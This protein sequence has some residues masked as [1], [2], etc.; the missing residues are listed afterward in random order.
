MSYF[1]YNLGLAVTFCL[2][3]PLLPFMLL[4][5]KRFSGGF[6]QRFGVYPKKLREYLGRDRPIWVHAASVGE[7]RAAKLLI[8]ALRKRFPERRLV[9][10]TFTQTGNELARERSS[11]EE[12][13]FLP[14]DFVW[15]VRRSLTTVKPSILILIETEIWP[16]LLREVHRRGIPAVL[17]SGRI[18]PRAFRRYRRIRWF[19]RDVLQNLTALGMQSEGDVA[20]VVS[21]GA[22]SRRVVMTG[23]I[24]RAVS[25][26]TGVGEGGGAARPNQPK[27]L[28]EQR[29]AFLW[30]AGS[31][32]PG[33]EEIVLAAFERLKKQFPTLRMVLAPR[34][35]Q[36][37]REVEK[38]LR[39]HGLEFEKKSQV[40]GKL[41]PERDVMILDTLGDL[42]SLYAIGDIAFVGG[43]LVDAGGH[44]LLEPARFAKPVLFGPH[45]ANV[46]ALAQDLVENGGG[47]RVRGCE[48]LVREITVLLAEPEK[49]TATGTRAFQVAS[50]GRGVLDQNVDLIA[51]CL[52]N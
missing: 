30:V 7:A 16:N 46:A 48:D 51:R 3:V 45:T 39:A 15:V 14:L 50:R 6:K 20:R 28:G 31:T 38:L 44:N 36:R 25:R 23:N 10:S 2:A 27:A 11:G 24:K 9:L 52:E 17:L 34:H 47:I 32:H 5:G 8:D 49:C 12:V 1:L 35:P 18:S 37:F 40:N 42:E 29:E 21:L 4:S 22:D 41:C 43:S 33:E 19:F 13:I 26:E